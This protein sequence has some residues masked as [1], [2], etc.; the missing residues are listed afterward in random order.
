[1]RKSS[2]SEIYGAR[3]TEIYMVREAQ[4]YIWC[5]RHRYIYG[6]RGTDIYMV[7]EAQRY[8]VREAQR[9]IRCERHRYIYGARGTFYLFY[10]LSVMKGIEH[11]I[12]VQ[13]PIYHS[14][15]SHVIRFHYA[16]LHELTRL[17]SYKRL[18]FNLC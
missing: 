5:E 2:G 17:L 15:S 3:G 11:N 16:Y 8:M 4:I 1:M 14:V 13:S 12:I 10:F 9:D 6:A 7:R 18:M